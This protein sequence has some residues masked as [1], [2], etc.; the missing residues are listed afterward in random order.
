MACLPQ[1]QRRQ[2]LSTAPLLDLATA[3]NSHWGEPALSPKKP[4]HFSRSLKVSLT[5][6]PIK[7]FRI[8]QRPLKAH[9]FALMT[10]HFGLSP[11][12]LPT[13]LPLP[14]SQ[15]CSSKAARLCHA[16]MGTSAGGWKAS[17]LFCKRLALAPNLCPI[18]RTP[19]GKSAFGKPARAHFFKVPRP[20]PKT[21]LNQPAGNCSKL[22]CHS[23]PP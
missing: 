23:K 7:P 22:P 11:A 21:R 10:K 1:F 12:A 3:Y 19:R 8:W 9:G 17:R 14:E 4:P 16:T 2:R 18:C 20:Q 15:L 5:P 6:R 13:S